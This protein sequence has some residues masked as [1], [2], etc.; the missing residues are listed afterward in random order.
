MQV[1]LI[2]G[3]YELFRSHFGAPPAKARDGKAVGA[4]R[5]L[6]RSVL[7]L[8]RDPNVTHV[9][10]AFDTVVESFRNDLFDGYK[11]GEGIEPELLA[12]F[13]LAERALRA[14]GVT[15]WSMVEFE[16]DDALMTAACRFAKQKK[17]ERVVICSP[18]KDLAQ[19]VVGD[20]VI[21]L[22]RRKRAEMNAEGVV[23]KFGVGPGSIP[24]YL[25]LVGDA[26]DGIPGIARWGAKSTGIVLG[27]YEKLE[28]IPDDV[29]EWEIEVRGAK[30]LA[31]NLSEGRDA[32][33]LYRRLATLRDD[34]PLEESL[35]DLKW[36]G[37]EREELE[38]FCAEIGFERFL[39]E[40]DR[41]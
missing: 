39:E 41:A 20:R 8:L 36:K 16:A 7:S 22:D 40:L 12:Q 15:V 19:A 17:V 4:T 10:A 28:N 26:A 21:C 9:A 25:A 1:H 37:P 34:V 31:A 24:D 6:M 23:E 5:G 2:D 38:A 13:P 29:G 3:T 35:A 11:T 18:D 30:T 32:A 14:L 27:H 33:E